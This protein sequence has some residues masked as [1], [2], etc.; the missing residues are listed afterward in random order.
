MEPVHTTQLRPDSSHRGLRESGASD[1]GGLD[2]ASGPQSR[3][4]PPCP[5]GTLC[6]VPA[7]QSA[8]LA[9]GPGVLLAVRE[10]LTSLPPPGG[11]G[12]G[13]PGGPFLHRP[14]HPCRGRAPVSRMAAGPA[15]GCLKASPLSGS[16][17]FAFHGP[18]PGFWDCHPQS[19]PSARICR[20]VSSGKADSG[21]LPL[22][23]GGWVIIFIHCCRLNTRNGPEV[24]S[25]VPFDVHKGS[26]LAPGLLAHPSLSRWRA[27]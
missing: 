14:Q 2:P 17:T 11:R 13:D 18:H 4:P 9:S 23:T 6:S 27:G 5:R 3:W 21:L 16:G 26:A 20:S 10:P 24:C 15:K 1:E 19:W 25:G 7:T 22:P 8:G 12:L